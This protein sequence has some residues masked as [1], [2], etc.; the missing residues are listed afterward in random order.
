MKA[1]EDVLMGRVA[2]SVCAA[3][4]MVPCTFF[5]PLPTPIVWSGLALSLLMHFLYQS[6]W[7]RAMHR[8]DLSL[9]FPIMRGLAPLLVGIGCY[10]IFDESLS[11]L[12]S[13]GLVI[14][15]LAVVSFGF[16]R[17]LKQGTSAK[18]SRDALFWAAMTS[19]GILG[20]S[21]ADANGIRQASNPFTYIVWLFLLDFIG[22]TT[23]ALVSRKA[24]FFDDLKPVLGK[25][26]LAAVMIVTSFGALLYGFTL[27]DAVRMTA[28][29]E[30]A[31]LFGAIFGWLI[32]K[33]SIGPRR[34]LASIVLVCGLVLMEIGA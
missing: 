33:E 19:I 5:V 16:L 22:M 20:Y 21:L 25:G 26:F 30:S 13:V 34:I 17:G 23:V 10:I 11:V 6:A 8:G 24:R 32:L 28:I 7:V 12:S 9:V 18:V 15:I 4:L 1:S 3:V 2:M 14:A 29:R 27:T 31:V